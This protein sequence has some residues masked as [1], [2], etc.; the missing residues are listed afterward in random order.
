MIV[1]FCMNNKIKKYIKDNPSASIPEVARVFNQQPADIEMYF[2]IDD[3]E[4]L[5]YNGNLEEFGEL[6]VK[7]SQEMVDSQLVDKDQ[8]EMLYKA[9]QIF[10]NIYKA[11]ANDEINSDYNDDELDIRYSD[12]KPVD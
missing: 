12:S 2:N 3:K 8:V 9:S 7:K 6:I 11:K 4:S 5:Q 10:N 1:F